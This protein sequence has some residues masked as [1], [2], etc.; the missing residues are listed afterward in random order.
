MAD[1]NLV[2][3]NLCGNDDYT[4]LFKAGEAQIHQIV[5]CNHCGLMY[6]NPRF[7]T[8]VP[9]RRKPKKPPDKN[10]L[11]RMFCLGLEKQMT[12]TRDYEKIKL[13]LN[14]YYPNRGK[15]VEIGSNLGYFLNSL[16]QDGWEVVGIEPSIYSCQYSI[17]E[18]DI[19]V[20]P[21]TLEETELSD[22]SLDAAVMTHVIEHVDDPLASFKKV[23]RILKPG[24]LFVVETP[25]YDTFMFKLLGKRERN[26]NCEGHIY[27]FTTNTFQKMAVKSGFNV[28]KLDYVGRSL[29]L[30]RVL[31]NVGTITRIGI[32]KK[33]PDWCLTTLHLSKIRLHVNLRDI[34]RMYLIKPSS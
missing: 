11:E 2:T 21:M 29:T 9:T 8:N 26:L 19:K 3:C 33:I 32:L 22:N 5:K 15:L 20:F 16:K 23:H 31:W 24:G 25:R 4:I 30:N 12:Q 10:T 1:M 28:L 27:F 6:A 7:K 18:W 14:K 34:Q 13:F 17:R